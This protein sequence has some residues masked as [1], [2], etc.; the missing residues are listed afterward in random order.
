MG[1]A[2]VEVGASFAGTSRSVEQ[3][4]PRVWSDLSDE[5]L[6][7]AVE[8]SQHQVVIGLRPI[9]A[10]GGLKDG[11][12]PLSRSEWQRRA[13]AIATTRE[14]RVRYTS[15]EMPHAV[16]EVANIE[17]LRALRKRSDVYFVEPAAMIASTSTPGCGAPA[18]LAQPTFTLPEGVV[19]TQGPYSYYWPATGATVPSTELCFGPTGL[20]DPVQAYIEVYVS[21]PDGA[22][23]EGKAWFWAY[24]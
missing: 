15:R 23:R 13:E 22:A 11:R 19:G 2:N 5:E 24:P 4:L 21:E 10:V 8:A 14:Y 20:D 3:Q 12:P 7:K 16:I 17:V 6:W 1:G 18:P 9:G